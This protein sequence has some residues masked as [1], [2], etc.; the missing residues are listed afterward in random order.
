MEGSEE[1]RETLVSMRREIDLLRT[2]V[3]HANLLIN[4]LDA[5]LCTDATVDPFV[6]VFSALL[7]VFDCSS[8]I[9]LVEQDGSKDT[10]ECASSSHDELT[11]T[12]WHINRTF[13]KVLS[14]R[15]ITTLTSSDTGGWP[16]QFGVNLSKDRPALFLPLRVRNKLGL[17]ML[18]RDA[19]CPG[20]DR[21]HVNLA[22]KFSLLASHALAATRAT[23]T[24][25]ESNR[26][27][28][29]ANQLRASQKELTFRAN[30]DQL[31][32]LPNRSYIQEI[33]NELLAGN[34][35]GEK[36]AIAFIDVDNFKQVND[37]YGHTA[38][39]ALLKGI[40]DRVRADIRKTD[41]IGR[42]SGD[43]FVIILNHFEKRSEITALVNRVRENLSKP[44]EIDGFRIDISASI[45]VAFFPAH[46]R[47]YETLRRNADTAMYQA[48]TSAK[49]SVGYFNRSLGKK[50]AEKMS[51]EH[52]L[53]TALTKREFKCAL[54]QKV[55]LRNASIV[56]F[57]VLVR[58]VDEQGIIH[59]PG[60]FLP[61]AG[62][63]GLLDDI[64][65]AMIDLLLQ[66]LPLLDATF[67]L[68]VTYSFNVSA[69]QAAKIA[70]MEKLI[71]RIAVSGRARSFTFELTEEAFI[72]AGAFQSKIFPLLR[73]VG[74]GVSID[75]FGTGY[76][77]LS[78]LADITANELK[79]DRSLISS[80]HNRP[81]NQ[82]ILRAIESLSTSL[83]ILLVAEGIE[84]PE[85]RDYLLNSSTIRLGQGY[86]FHKPQFI[87]NLIAEHRD[88][89]RVGCLSSSNLGRIGRFVKRGSSP[90]EIRA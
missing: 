11:G 15:I 21:S 24:E 2:E 37:F 53:R 44:F 54:Q 4:A 20:F 31:T 13:R 10:L 68:D 3:K 52:R 55:D 74:I 89:M 90:S 29:L 59:P 71:Q 62:E 66:E 23:Q 79:V 50:A 16:S 19:N 65:R 70:F 51:L 40:A 86:L 38:G 7:P 88:I 58:W 82:G 83:G 49:G 43:E 87:T 17:L 78:T 27:K 61:L 12:V 8:A 36:R 9:V 47:D 73:E 56:G 32:G 1:L 69:A 25:A 18:L 34:Q 81:R 46:G 14:G 72:A 41:F 57:E 60:K 39:D 42:I 77:S 30:H 76:S 64:A 45:G 33:V 22:W 80:I 26:F 28:Q 85:E 63:L 35:A 48:K 75:D 84:S 5:V 67:G 6:G